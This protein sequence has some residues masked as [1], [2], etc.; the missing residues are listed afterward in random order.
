MVESLFRTDIKGWEEG[1][2][3]IEIKAWEK[4]SLEQK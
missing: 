3:R 2:R 4:V 1:F